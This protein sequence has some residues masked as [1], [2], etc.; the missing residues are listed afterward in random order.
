M[1]WN[2]SEDIE[3]VQFADWV[4]PETHDLFVLLTLNP[5]QKPNGQLEARLNQI[6]DRMKYEIHWVCPDEFHYYSASFG[7]RNLFSDRVL[8]ECK[9]PNFFVL[10]SAIKFISNLYK[11]KK[12]KESKDES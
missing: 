5:G 2:F 3:L 11:E 9:L 10:K 1:E 8:T 7:R 4:F 12:A 6:Q